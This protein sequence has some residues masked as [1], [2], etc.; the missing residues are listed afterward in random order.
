MNVLYNMY[1]VTCIKNRLRFSIIYRQ[2]NINSSYITV[3]QVYFLETESLQEK[4]D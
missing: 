3:L 1:L 2:K 4:R